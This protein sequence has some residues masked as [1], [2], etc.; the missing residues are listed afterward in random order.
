MPRP[1]WPPLPPWESTPAGSSLACRS[2]RVVRG[3]APAES[4]RCARRLPRCSAGPVRGLRRCPSLSKRRDKLPSS[5][6][7]SIVIVVAAEPV[8][9]VSFDFGTARGAGEDR[10]TS[11]PPSAPCGLS[12]VSKNSPSCLGSLLAVTAFPPPESAGVGPPFGGFPVLCGHPT[13]PVPSSSRPFVLDDYR[14]RRGEAGRSPR[15]RTRNFVPNPSPI[16][17]PTDG[18]RASCRWPA[19]PRTRALRH[20]AC[21]RFGTAPSDFHQT[22]PCS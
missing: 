11:A 16:R 20:F 8:P 17:A 4:P 6:T 18:Y 9:L 13:P 15:V 2:R 12:A 3:T 21:V 22:P 19:R 5:A 7:S 1:R 10:S 14:R